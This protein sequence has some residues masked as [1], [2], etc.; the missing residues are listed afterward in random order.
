MCRRERV[1]CIYENLQNQ[2]GRNT[3]YV[4]KLKLKVRYL[5]AT[6]N[7]RCVSGFV[8]VAVIAV[9][10]AAVVVAAAAEI[11]LGGCQVWHPLHHPLA[12]SKCFSSPPQRTGSQL[13]FPQ[14]SKKWTQ[15]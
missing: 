12:F 2:K 5:L 8:V 14:P 15:G 11:L 7:S 6:I 10:V 13:E 9:V 3:V 4:V 1:I